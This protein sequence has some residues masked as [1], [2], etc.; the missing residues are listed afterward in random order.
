MGINSGAYN[1]KAIIG[2]IG[3]LFFGTFTMISQKFILDLSAC[4]RYV[5]KIHAPIKPWKHGQCPKIL[6]EKFEKIWFKTLV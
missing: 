3:I 5:E 4:P 6:K 1:K 2:I